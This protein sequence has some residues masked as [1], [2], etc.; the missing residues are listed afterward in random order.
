MNHIYFKESH[1][2][3]HVSLPKIEISVHV[4]RTNLEYNGFQCDPQINLIP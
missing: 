2:L 4:P 1:V 3:I